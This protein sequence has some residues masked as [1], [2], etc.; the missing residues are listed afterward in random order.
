MIA[1]T[2]VASMP[3]KSRGMRRRASSRGKLLLAAQQT[4]SA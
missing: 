4:A 2:V 1:T 3:L